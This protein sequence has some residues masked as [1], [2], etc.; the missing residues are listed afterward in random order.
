MRAGRA[1]RNYLDS[2]KLIAAIFAHSDAHPCSMVSRKR[3]AGIVDAAVAPQPP[4]SD[5]I[6]AAP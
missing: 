6:V 2:P 5:A 1:P 3:K 4:T